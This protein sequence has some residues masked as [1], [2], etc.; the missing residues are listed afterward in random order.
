MLY[1]VITSARRSSSPSGSTS[2]VSA[3]GMR[4]RANLDVQAC[5]QM[6]AIHHHIS[7][8]M[9]RRPGA[10]GESAPDQ[11]EHW[12]LADQ[13][14]Q[15][16]RIVRRAGNPGNRYAH[17]QLVAVRPSDIDT[18]M[19]AQVRW[20]LCADNGDLS[21]GIRLLPGLPA[22]VAVRSGGNTPSIV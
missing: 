9:F 17:A 12:Q 20:L 19:L 6:A 22:P 2:I 8:S 16:M 10:Q 3:P 21:A 5:N 1:E 13:S 14:A 18:F 15:G 4:N 11:L 7:G